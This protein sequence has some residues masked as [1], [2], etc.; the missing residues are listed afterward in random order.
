MSESASTTSSASA[1]DDKTATVNKG[2]DKGGGGGAGEAEA[3]PDFNS[4]YFTANE[5]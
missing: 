1:L 4:C 2:V 3:P 5:R